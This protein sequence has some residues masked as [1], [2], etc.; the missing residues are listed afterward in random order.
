MDLPEFWST[1]KDL[2]FQ[3]IAQPSVGFLV[4]YHN[5]A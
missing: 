5:R 1:K 4:C 2:K 3:R